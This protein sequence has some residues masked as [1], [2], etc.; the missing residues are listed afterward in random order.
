LEPVSLPPRETMAF[1]TH[2]PIFIGTPSKIS[3]WVSLFRAYSTPEKPS[4]LPIQ[5]K[6]QTLRTV[7]NRTSIHY[8]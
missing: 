4:W 5:M 2:V 1:L 6:D 7:G 8:Y 3:E